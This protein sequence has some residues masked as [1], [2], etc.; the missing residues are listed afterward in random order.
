MR[1]ALDWGGGVDGS[2]GLVRGGLILNDNDAASTVRTDLNQVTL[3]DQKKKKD[4]GD[5]SS[6][7]PWTCSSYQYQSQ[8]PTPLDENASHV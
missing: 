3:T 8:A 5:G 7:S 2:W 1:F 6:S 4:N